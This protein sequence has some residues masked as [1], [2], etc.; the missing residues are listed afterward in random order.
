MNKVFFLAAAVLILTKSY[1]L[2]L[3]SHL[4]YSVLVS[5]LA[6]YFVFRGGKILW[7][8]IYW[9]LGLFVLSFVPSFFTS[10][11][12]FG[13]HELSTFATGLLVFLLALNW[14]N[15]NLDRMMKGFVALAV[16]F[17][18]IGFGD[19]L[20]GPSERLAGAFL[21]D[22]TYSIYPNAMASLLLF[23]LPINY[24]ISRSNKWWSLALFINLTAFWLT[25][26]RAALLVFLMTALFAFAIYY[27]RNFNLKR[28]WKPVGILFLSVLA[29]FL[30]NQLNP[31][32]IDLQERIV[33]ED[34]PSQS[35]VEERLDF[36][37]GAVEMGVDNLWLGVGPGGF[38]HFYPEYQNDLLALS[39]HPHNV[40][41][42]LFAESGSFAALFFLGFIAFAFGRAFFTLNSEGKTILFLAVLALF[43]HNLIDYHLNFTLIGAL[44]FAGLGILL[45]GLPKKNVKGSNHFFATVGL[46]LFVVS[47]LH[48]YVMWNSISN[49]PFKTAGETFHPEVFEN[50]SEDYIDGD[51][52]VAAVEDLLAMDQ[53][54][55]G[56]YYLLDL[57]V[58]DGADEALIWANEFTELLSVNAHQAVVSENPEAVQRIYEYLGEDV[59]DEYNKFLEVWELEMQKFNERYGTNLTTETYD[60]TYDG[61]FGGNTQSGQTE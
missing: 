45:N 41:L 12:P 33:F 2:D 27:W 21:G 16:L 10:Q 30:V 22:F 44:F 40:F 3:Q 35:S 46:A 42:K 14:K 31:Q 38:Q 18:I 55:S 32:Q 11:H 8:P 52:D 25:A 19:L 15:L 47:V 13:F 49:A 43:G 58:G 53:Y 28:S 48:G 20:L 50:L 29:T 23:S 57:L 39:D 59:K 7:H 9:V 24:Y 54:N 1:M 56:K 5:S 60:E 61:Y 36:W 26:S 51:L 6:M 34:V 37:A 4:V 17:S